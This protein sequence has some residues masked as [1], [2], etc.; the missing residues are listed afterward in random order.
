MP[1]HRFGKTLV[2]FSLTVFLT[3]S[4]VWAQP[5]QL[6]PVRGVVVD[7]LGAPVSDVVLV[8]RD[9]A[10][11]DRRTETDDQGRFDVT[12]VGVG[13]VRVSIVAAGWEPFVRELAAGAA[14]DDLR[15]E[16]RP[17]GVQETVV[18]IGSVERA[19]SP[20]PESASLPTSVDIMGGDQIARENVGPVVTNS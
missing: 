15:I 4:S 20:H 14:Q 12:G 2:A 5:P 19:R 13:P 3:A 6:T 16:L 1:P 8:V 9:A 10:G 7:P 18:V 11:V 17:A